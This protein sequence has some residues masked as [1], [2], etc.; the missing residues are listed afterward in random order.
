MSKAVV[1]QPQQEMHLV[2]RLR[3]HC[4]AMLSGIL[5]DHLTFQNFLAI[6]DG[7]GEEP[8]ADQQIV[9]KYKG[10]TLNL[11]KL[12]S[13]VAYRA[14]PH[15][16]IK[17]I[18]AAYV[19]SFVNEVSANPD[20]DPTTKVDVTDVLSKKTRDIVTTYLSSAAAISGSSEQEARE[21]VPIYTSAM[22]LAGFADADKGD[23][24]FTD[25]LRDLKR[26]AEK[27]VCVF[28]PDDLP[29]ATPDTPEPPLVYSAPYR[30]D[31]DNYTRRMALLKPL[32]TA[33]L[34][35]RDAW[36]AIECSMGESVARRTVLGADETVYVLSDVEG[37]YHVLLGCLKQKGVIS[38][39]ANWNIKWMKNEVWVI[40][41][42]DAVDDIRW[43]FGEGDGSHDAA[44]EQYL[45]RDLDALFVFD[46][47]RRV[48]RGR[49]INLIGNHD[50]WNLQGEALAEKNATSYNILSRYDQARY[51]VADGGPSLTRTQF[52]KR[53]IVPFFPISFVHVFRAHAYD[54]IASHAGLES[55]LVNLLQAKALASGDPLDLI[56]A[57]KTIHDKLGSQAGSTIGQLEYEVNT[58]SR[59]YSE[60]AFDCFSDEKNCVQGSTEDE[61]KHED[62]KT[63]LA[64]YFSQD[65]PKRSVIQVMGHNKNPQMVLRQIV[66]GTTGTIEAPKPNP[67]S[68]ITINNTDGTRDRDVVLCAVDALPESEQHPN[69]VQVLVVKSGI[70][71]TET[72]TD[73]KNEIQKIQAHYM[74]AIKDALYSVDKGAPK[75]VVAADPSAAPAPT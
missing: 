50:L 46:Y 52:V 73:L 41:C 10:K 17:Q 49:F 40:H 55:K 27:T 4:E 34:A 30:M 51:K 58:M 57:P 56:H 39:D 54:I 20:A 8:P 9:A 65:A 75:V 2:K 37:R 11:H 63:N 47:L 23:L 35:Q 25:Y 69:K 68:P 43:T 6:V 26:L 13:N 19:C 7:G 22:R 14:V 1:L 38:I 70:V 74:G 60:T 16:L 67:T 48:S 33:T 59:F 44:V 62:L 45:G 72:C 61:D 71:K 21:L 12:F 42:G 28:P 36:K 66:K 3:D 5:P 31:I 18:C 64:G 24:T 29:A 32:A 53:Y 15:F